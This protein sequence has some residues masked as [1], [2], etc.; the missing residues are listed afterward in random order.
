[1]LSVRSSSAGLDKDNEHGNNE[2]KRQKRRIAQEQ[3]GVALKNA[4][5]LF[6]F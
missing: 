4:V 5:V 6:C 2:I 1:M 3:R